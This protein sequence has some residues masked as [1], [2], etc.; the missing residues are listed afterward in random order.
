M[1]AV[2]RFQIEKHYETVC[3][4]WTAQKWPCVPLAH[5]PKTGVI[6]TLDGAPAAAAWLY[7]TDSAIC[8]LEFI[9]ADP[10][11]RRERRAAILSVLLSSLKLIAETMGYQTIFTSGKNVSLG[12]RLKLQGFQPT[13]EGVTQY[14]HTIQG[15]G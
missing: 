4:W 7:R 9:V 10:E 2:E 11:V 8:W 12:E 6:V 5:L 15:G 1:I 3:G 13:D 14:I